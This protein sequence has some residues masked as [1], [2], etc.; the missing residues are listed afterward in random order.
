M[1]EII[2]VSHVSMEKGRAALLQI[3][4]STAG[5]PSIKPVLDTRYRAEFSGKFL[6]PGE[7]EKFL[8]EV[9]TIVSGLQDVSTQR[10]VYYALRGA[11]PEWTY[12][13]EALGA[14]FYQHLIGWI[15]EK[16]QLMTGLTMQS[17]GIWPGNRGYLVGDGSITT[18]LRGKMPISSKPMLGFDMVDEGSEVETH[19]TKLI[20][21]EKEAGLDGIVSRDFPKYVEAIFST[22]QGQPTESGLKFLRMMEDQGMELYAVHDGDPSGIQMQLQYGMASKNNCYMPE[23]FYPQLVKPL[24]FYPSIGEALNLPPEDVKDTEEAI[25]GNLIALANEKQKMFP[26]LKRFGMAREVNVITQLRQKWEFQALNAIHE[27]APKIYILEGLRVHNDPIK[28]VPEAQDI[29]EALIDVARQYAEEEVESSLKKLAKHLY[30]TQIERELIDLLRDGC[31]EEIA[32]FTE[33]VDQALPRLAAVDAH[34]YREEVKFRLL[35]NPALYAIEVLKKYA[36]EL[37]AVDFDPRARLETSLGVTISSVVSTVTP[38]PPPIHGS[39]SKTELTN[40]IEQRIIPDTK[41]RN[42]VVSLIRKAL[43]DRFGTPSEVW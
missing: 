34:A 25:F 38:H 43:E 16:T 20:H 41:T 18:R 36:K 26:Q 30:D 13:D 4:F 39:I 8:Q 21:F 27:M 1:A 42:R 22:T 5:I 11:H 3:D 29:K 12:K 23:E 40:A 17:L 6:N 14:D 37:L 9:R 15:M 2:E 28:S 10:A 31:A 24:G 7:N 19:A 35:K 33:K 32:A